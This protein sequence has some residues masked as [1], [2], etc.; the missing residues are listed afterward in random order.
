MKKTPV[1]SRNGIE[2]K[3]IVVRGQMVLLDRDVAD[4]Y[5]VETKH[6]NQAVKNNPDK[7]PEGYV[8]ELDDDEMSQVK[9]FDLSKRSHYNSKVFTEKGLYMLATIL[10]SA[11]ATEATISIIETYSKLKEMGREM[12]QAALST[13]IENKRTLMNRAGKLLTDLAS[14]AMEVA[15]DEFTMELNLVAIRLSRKVKRQI[16]DSAGK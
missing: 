6:V 4:L 16:K 10:K 2:D 9:I 11:V 12:Q 13:D 7:F 15:E 1:L 14:D 3:M 5:G 8:L